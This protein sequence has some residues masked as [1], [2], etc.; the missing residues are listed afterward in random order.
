MLTSVKDQTMVAE[1]IASGV[2]S[3]ILKPFTANTLYEK[4]EFVLHKDKKQ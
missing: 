2:S 1:A 3:Y 4:I